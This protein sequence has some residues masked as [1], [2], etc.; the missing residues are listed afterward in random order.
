MV[1]WWRIEALR[2]RTAANWLAEVKPWL[3]SQRWCDAVLA[4]LEVR[5]ALGGQLAGQVKW[6]PEKLKAMDD[7]VGLAMLRDAIRIPHRA[8]DIESYGKRCLDTYLR[9][10]P[11]EPQPVRVELHYAQGTTVTSAMGS[12]IVTRWG[13]RGVQLPASA[14]PA[15]SQDAVVWQGTPDQTPPSPIKSLFTE[16]MLWLSIS[17]TPR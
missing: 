14:L 2:Q 9:L 10:M 4:A 15:P 17:R 12:G 3:A 8:E 13:M 5:A 7:Q 1:E 6:L 16:D 11:D